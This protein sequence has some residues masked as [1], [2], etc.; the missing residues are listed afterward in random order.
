MPIIY[1]NI[2]CDDKKNPKFG[3]E[4]T[5]RRYTFNGTNKP[6][7]V[8]Y[9]CFSPFTGLNKNGHGHGQLLAEAKKRGIEDFVI[10][11]PNKKETLDNNRN[12]FTLQQKVEIAKEGCKD[13]GFNILDAFISKA[14]NVLP[15]LVN[16]AEKF[17][18]RRIVLICGPDRIDNYT[19]MGLIPYSKGNNPE[20]AETQFELFGVTDRDAS[21]VSG[22]RVR[23]AIRNNDKEGFLNMTGYSEKMWNLCRGMAEKNGVLTESM[24][25]ALEATKRQGIYHLYNPGNAMEFPQAQFLDL[26]EY[27]ESLGKLVNGK[28]FSI[29]EKPDGAAFRMGI[30]DEGKFFIEQSYSGP[31]YDSDFIKS[32]YSQKTGKMNRLGKGWKNLMDTLQSDTKT[33]TCL[34]KIYNEY[35]AFKVMAEIFITELGYDEGD[36]LVSFVS[37]RYHRNNIG[38]D[39]TIVMYDVLGADNKSLDDYKSIMNYLIKN[40]S[41]ASIKYDNNEMVT[42]QNIVINL[43]STLTT[44]KKNINDLSNEVGDIEAILANTSRKKDDQA[45]KKYV[46]GKIEEQQGIL[47]TVFEQQLENYQGKWGPDY[48]GVIIEFKNGI[49]L[50]ITSKKFKEFKASHDDTVQ[51]WLKDE[52]DESYENY[53]IKSANFILESF[54]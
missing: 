53:L 34:K 40:G 7:G 8:I 32:K 54:N 20:G 33:Q 43:K 15:T 30:D 19:N 28:N 45:V 52:M 27:L 24:N 51:K 4:I 29:R 16:I 13:V 21:D 48:E 46:K 50:K 5:I 25:E 42:E 9:G 35:G 18:N 2:I 11:S 22:T 47:N 10:C 44:I 39:A 23:E 31:I 6:L 26:V 37:T 17:D 1:K 12:M 41:S 36:D 49:L 38:K 3:E 14:T